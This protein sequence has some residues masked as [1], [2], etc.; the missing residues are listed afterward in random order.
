MYRIKN[1]PTRIFR[2]IKPQRNTKA[3]RIAKQLLMESNDLTNNEKEI[4]ARVS[5]NVHYYDRMYKSGLDGA[6]HYLSVG[7]SA[8][9]CIEQALLQQGR[10]SSIKKILDFP[11]GYGR[12]L[13]F[14][15]A[16][17]PD[18]EISGAE[19]NHHGLNFCR[20]KFDIKTILSNKQLSDINLTHKFDLIWC[21]SLITHIDEN[22]MSDLL[23][24]FFKHLSDDGLCVFTSHGTYSAEQIK[25]QKNTYG[26]SLEAQKSILEDYNTIG[27]GFVN[28]KNVSGYGISLIS[29]KRVIELAKKV[30]NWNLVMFKPRGWDTHHDVYAFEKRA[31]TK[32]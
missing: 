23:K 22:A 17:F 31:K 28:Y 27:H 14:L 6:S 12:V 11:C 4:I 29:Q 32:I 16:K 24:L 13:R 18:A 19:I 7:L 25:S 10:K 5:L 9:H 20:R 2:K 1:L 26:L 21:G 15:R 8:N 3:L 30:G